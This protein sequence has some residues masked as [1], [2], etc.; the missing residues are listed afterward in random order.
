AGVGA[1]G[2][3]GAAAGVFAPRMAVIAASSQPGIPSSSSAAARAGPGAGAG[4]EPPPG[5]VTP[6]AEPGATGAGP[7]PGW[8]RRPARGA[9]RV[10]NMSPQLG[11][12]TV[13]PTCCSP[14]RV[15]FRQPGQTTENGT[16]ELLHGAGFASTK[17]ARGTDGWRWASSYPKPA[18]KQCLSTGGL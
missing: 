7:G 15:L 12:E 16:G 17:R 8:P 1:G 5:R 11:Q 3:A 13:C 9:A 10:A 18:E 2:G 14:I 4:A 6:G